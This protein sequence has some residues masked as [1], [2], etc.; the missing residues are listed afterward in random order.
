MPRVVKLNSIKQ[1]RQYREWINVDAIK[2]DAIAALEREG[3][4]LI[5]LA[6]ASRG[7][8]N[9][10]MN[11]K[12]SYCFGVFD[13]R[14]LVK[15]GFLTRNPEAERENRGWNGRLEAEAFLEEIG[16]RQKREGLS[17]VIGV[18]LFYGQILEDKW[19]YRVLANIHTELQELDQYGIQGV[20]YKA[21]YNVDSDYSIQY[22]RDNKL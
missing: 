16:S 3:K 9:R 19:G 20:K 6:Y 11:L 12:D 2:N 10:T 8:E 17:L 1:L 13:G 18:A 5:Q 15:S 4:R 21:H 14:K 7:F 22:R